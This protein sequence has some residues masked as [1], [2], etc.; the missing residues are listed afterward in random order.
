MAWKIL[1][2]TRQFAVLATKSIPKYTNHISLVQ[3]SI[4]DDDIQVLKC[5]ASEGSKQP[6]KPDKLT[7]HQLNEK[8]VKLVNLTDNFFYQVKIIPLFSFKS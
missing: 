2:P 1:I 7:E 4:R 3:K 8:M 5:S 6:D